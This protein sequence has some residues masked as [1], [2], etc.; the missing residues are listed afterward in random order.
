MLLVFNRS[1]TVSCVNVILMFYHL[2]R[3]NSV[4]LSVIL[5]FT[6]P[7]MDQPDLTGPVCQQV[8]VLVSSH[9]RHIH[10]SA[11]FQEKRCEN[12]QQLK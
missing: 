4:C 1:I 9:L 12:F 6:F 2:L 10:L 5:V 11:A 8:V 7:C 3:L